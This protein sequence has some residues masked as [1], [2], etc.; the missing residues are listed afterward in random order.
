MRRKN[1]TEREKVEKILRSIKLQE[2]SDEE[3]ET[4][5][6]ELQRIIANR[7]YEITAERDRKRTLKRKIYYSL[8]SVSLIIVLIAVGL[9][10]VKPFLNREAVIKTIKNKLG[11]EVSIEDVLLKNGEG[12]VINDNREIVVNISSGEYKTYSPMSYEPSQEEKDKAVQIVKSSEEAKSFVIKEGE[13]PVNISENPI[14]LIQG[15]E[16]PHSGMKYVEVSLKF[17]PSIQ[18]PQGYIPMSSVKFTVDIAKGK[19]LEIEAK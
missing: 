19:V 1:K 10:L 4:N 11:V 3:I 14:I 13:A 12:I 5:K 16:F 9:L 2:L 15:Y 8:A 18:P 17:T 7:F 6:N